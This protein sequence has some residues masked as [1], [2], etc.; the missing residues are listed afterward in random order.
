MLPYRSLRGRTPKT[1]TRM[2][3][4]IA[5]R[6]D[7]EI[8]GPS[9]G[10]RHRLSDETNET[11]SEKVDREQ[12]RAVLWGIGVAALGMMTL[13]QPLIRYGDAVELGCLGLTAGMFAFLFDASYGFRGWLRIAF[14]F[15]SLLMLTFGAF[16]AIPLAKVAA[17]RSAT[18]DRRCMAIQL[19][20]L[21]AHPR[22]ADGPALFHALGCV[23]TDDPP[24]KTRE[25]SARQL[26]PPRED[27]APGQHNRSGAG[28]LDAN[29][30]EPG[31]A[32]R[33]VR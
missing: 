21:S 6:S 16:Q 10:R 29:D 26:Q 7:S 33:K 23:P 1:P 22:R 24:P 2:I 4:A 30:Q 13:G 9:R 15:M 14:M 12:G 31:I 28:T 25:L 18:N 3:R 19:D 27:A 17:R 5:P 20:M 32:N 11:N 8:P